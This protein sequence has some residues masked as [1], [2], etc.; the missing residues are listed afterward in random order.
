MDRAW[1]KL[2]CAREILRQAYVPEL[3]KDCYTGEVGEA[4]LLKN[5][6]MTGRD[7]AKGKIISFC[8]KKD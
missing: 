5:E 6:G 8:G 1:L 2:K 3:E 4:C 7:D